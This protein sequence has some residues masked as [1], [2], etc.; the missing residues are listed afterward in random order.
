MSECLRYVETEGGVGKHDSVQHYFKGS[1]FP[2]DNHSYNSSII[3]ILSDIRNRKVKCRA[4]IFKTD[5]TLTRPFF[6]G[7]L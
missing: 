2:F 7:Q 3:S 5:G 1:K 4:I 6:S